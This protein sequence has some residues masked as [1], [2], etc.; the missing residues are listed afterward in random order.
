MGD[1]E[2]NE[3][4]KYVQEF[5]TKAFDEVNDLTKDN[6]HKAPKCDY[7]SDLINECIIFDCSQDKTGFLNQIQEV[8]F[9]M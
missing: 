5:V 7:L 3:T 1:D 4:L 6:L 9:F 8:L 2:R